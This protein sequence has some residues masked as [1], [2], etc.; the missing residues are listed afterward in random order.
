MHLCPCR[1][2]CFLFCPLQPSL[3]ISTKITYLLIALFSSTGL[4]VRF[5]IFITIAIRLF[6]HLSRHT[7][8]SSHTFLFSVWRSSKDAL[9]GFFPRLHLP[10][11][12]NYRGGEG[13]VS[14]SQL[15]TGTTDALGGNEKWHRPSFNSTHQSQSQ[16]Q[17]QSK[18]SVNIS[19]SVN[20][21]GGKGEEVELSQ[22]IANEKSSDKSSNNLRKF[23]FRGIWDVI[24]QSAYSLMLPAGVMVSRGILLVS[25]ILAY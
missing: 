18:H 14:K 11:N 25:C 3:P 22:S 23:E 9:V 13:G 7:P 2:F 8:F 16:S 6:T 10:S 5:I 21:L 4:F 1:A 12:S 17:S 15:R 20:K 19:G 24:T